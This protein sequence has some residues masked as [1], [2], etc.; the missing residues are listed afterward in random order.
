VTALDAMA[1]IE[2]IFIVILFFGFAIAVIASRRV[3]QG[4]DSVGRSLAQLAFV[5]LLPFIGPL[6]TMH[7]LRT[8]SE[9][10]SGGYAPDHSSLEDGAHI[11][12]RDASFATA[13]NESVGHGES[14]E[15]GHA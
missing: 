8:G 15:G 6:V 11:N 12:Q 9:R 13:R 4:R 2:L 14:V 1:P 7:L 3:I 10:G 5:W